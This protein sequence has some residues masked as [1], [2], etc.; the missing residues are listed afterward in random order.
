MNDHVINEVLET[1]YR[2]MQYKYSFT[3]ELPLMAFSTSI[4]IAISQY[5]GKPTSK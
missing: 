5:S 4:S 1:F 3:D 2:Y